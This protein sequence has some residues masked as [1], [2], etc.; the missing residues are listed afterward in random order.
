[1]EESIHVIFDEANDLLS[2]KKEDANDVGIIEEGMKEL[3]INDSNER[4]KEQLKE[5]H[6]DESINDQIIQEQPQDTSNLPK[7]WRYVHNHPKELII[8]DPI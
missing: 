8:G 3:T 1:M 2:K 7:E 6:E 4:N 5:K